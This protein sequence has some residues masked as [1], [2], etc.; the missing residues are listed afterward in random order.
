MLP[1]PKM[2]SGKI[3]EGYR[4]I[5]N[6]KLRTNNM[7]KTTQVASFKA[8]CRSEVISWLLGQDFASW[9]K[10]KKS[11]KSNWYKKLKTEE[12]LGKTYKVKQVELDHI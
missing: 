7:Y 10:L 1:K 8:L 2:Y 12:A 9:D 4:F 3:S 6:F 11:F 5:D